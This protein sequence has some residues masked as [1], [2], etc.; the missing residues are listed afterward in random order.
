MSTTDLNSA[1]AIFPEFS[2]IINTLSKTIANYEKDGFTSKVLLDFAKAFGIAEELADILEKPESSCKDT[3]QRLLG[4]FTN[5]VELLIQKTW[6]EKSDEDLREQLLD[7]LPSMVEASKT[8]NYAQAFEVLP[9]FSRD[10]AQLLFGMDSK[11]SDFIEY[12]G[13]I[14]PLLGLFW[15]Y[16]SM[17]SECAGRADDSCARHLLFVA[18][19]YLAFF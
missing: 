7:H 4:H 6:I 12:V 19:G 1:I 13:R 5:N 9:A 18:I 8:G 11:K 16:S 14:D 3:E 2:Q 17:V 10:L 15:L